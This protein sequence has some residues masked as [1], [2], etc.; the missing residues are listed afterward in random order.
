MADTVSCVRCQKD[1]PRIAWPP[2]AGEAG[3][4]IVRSVCQSCWPEWL[5]LQT[6]IINEYRLNVLDPNHQQMVAEQCLVFFGLR[7]G[8]QTETGTP[9]EEKG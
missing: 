2:Y 6:R 9:P 3:E 4:E 7:E 5:D 8:P 1:G